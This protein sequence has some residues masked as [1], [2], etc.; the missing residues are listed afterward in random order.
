[1][2]ALR[3]IVEVSGTAMQTVKWRAV[4]RAVVVHALQTPV[5]LVT[6]YSPSTRGKIFGEDLD[7]A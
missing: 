6:A 2:F 4:Q 7:C 3:T 1:M 5:G